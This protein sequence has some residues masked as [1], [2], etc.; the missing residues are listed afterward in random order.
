MVLITDSHINLIKATNFSDNFLNQIYFSENLRDL[1]RYFQIIESKLLLGLEYKLSYS[2]LSLQ[3]GKNRASFAFGLDVS[4]NVASLVAKNPEQGGGNY[5]QLFGVPYEQ[6]IKLDFEGKYFRSLGKLTWAN[7]LFTGFGVPY[8]NS[9]MLPQTKQYFSGGSNGLRGFVA[10]SL[11][12]GKTAPGD[13]TQ[14]LLGANSQGDIKLEMNSEMRY[15]ASSYVEIAGFVDAGNIWTYRDDTFYGEGA[16]FTKDFMNEMAV[17]AGLGLRFDFTYLIIRF[18][19]AT[20]LRKPW[21]DKPWVL[22][23]FQFGQK[24]WRKQNIIKNIAIAYPF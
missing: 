16:K 2:P 15:K 3:S 22:D 23:D 12:P 17:D 10:R 24:E 14:E 4:G 18:D 20:P 9:L 7:R 8:K 1:E 19:L 11:G 21:L 5:K 6:F 13:F